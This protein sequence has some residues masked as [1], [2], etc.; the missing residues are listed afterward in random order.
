M[1]VFALIHFSPFPFFSYS[2]ITRSRLFSHIFNCLFFSRRPGG[3]PEPRVHPQLL[4]PEGGRRRLLR[5]PRQGEA[6]AK[7][8]SLD[9]RREFTNKKCPIKSELFLLDSKRN[10]RGPCPTTKRYGPNFRIFLT[11]Y[12]EGHE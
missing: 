7:A 8:H 9:A 11:T 10:N 12:Y 5:V 6:A 1:T 3:P 2:M 4:E